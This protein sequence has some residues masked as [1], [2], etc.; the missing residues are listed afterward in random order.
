MHD[1]GPTHGEDGYRVE[2]VGC[3]GGLDGIGDEVA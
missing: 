1:S 3:D 2:P